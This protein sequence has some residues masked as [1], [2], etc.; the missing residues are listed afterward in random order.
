[1]SLATI[2]LAVT[3]KLG[4]GSDADSQSWLVDAINKAAREAYAGTDLV[5]SVCEQYFQY[6]VDENQATFPHYVGHLRAIRGS[7]LRYPIDVMAL[8]PRYHRS[9]WD[10]ANQFKFRVRNVTPLMQHSLNS[11]PLTITI[12]KAVATD[13]SVVVTGSTERAAKARETI[14]IP[15]GSTSAIGQFS[16]SPTGLMPQGVSTL[17]KGLTEYDVAVTDADDTV[18]AVLASNRRYSR[19]VIVELFERTKIATMTNTAIE[20]LYK[21]FLPELVEDSDELP[22]D[23]YDDAIVWKVLENEAGKPDDALAYRAKYEAVCNAISADAEHSIQTPIDMGRSR[24]ISSPNEYL[25]YS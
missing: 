2:K 20:V 4:I 19:Y 23:G 15:A 16:F 21:Q 17:T 6:R 12:P 9:A 8:S 1:M 10:S 18:L 22:I 14:T 5:G 7:N 3:R 13:V 24:F 25:F 11:A